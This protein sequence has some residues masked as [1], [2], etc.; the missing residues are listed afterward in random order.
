MELLKLPYV[1]STM[2]R[3]ISINLCFSV[4][5]VANDIAETGVRLM[6]EYKDVLTDDEEQRKMILHCVE[7]MRKLYPDFKKTTLAKKQLNLFL[8]FL[9][10]CA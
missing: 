8:I 1:Y 7:E 10:M 3:A 5:A 6:E 4:Q 2:I 9:S